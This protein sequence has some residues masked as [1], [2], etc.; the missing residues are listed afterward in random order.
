MS[1]GVPALYPLTEKGAR[2]PKCAR[3]RNHGMVSWL[4]GHKRHC[5]YKDCTC[6]K[7]N[8]IA[9]RQRVMAAQVALKRQQ[10]AEDAIAL[11]I[12]ACVSETG[13]PVMTQGPL[14]GPG[15]VTA[16]LD[17]VDPSMDNRNL[18]HSGPE[19][20]DEDSCDSQTELEVDSCSD[21]NPD[22]PAPGSR[23]QSPH[24][25]PTDPS[26]V[27]EDRDQEC[28]EAISATP[29]DYP[30]EA[31]DPSRPLD[32]SAAVIPSTAH[33]S[34][35]SDADKTSQTNTAHSKSGG[36]PHPHKT[37]NNPHHNH[38]SQYSNSHNNHHVKKEHTGSGKSSGSVTASRSASDHTRA[39]PTGYRPGRLTPLEILERVFP[40]QRRS[41]LELVLQGCNGDLVKAIEHFIS[42]QDTVAAQHQASL[43]SS[44]NAAAV[45][46]RQHHQQ[47]QQQQHKHQHHPQQLQHDG[48]VPPRPNPFISSLAAAAASG[49]AVFGHH[50]LNAITGSSNT[51][52]T[53]NNSMNVG[54]SGAGTDKLGFSHEL[55]G[56]GQAL[57]H[58]FHA[59]HHTP[60]AAHSGSGVGSKL[61][62]CSSNLK[63][64]FTPLSAGASTHGL[65]S[66]FT[67]HL[68]HFHHADAALR[69]PFF[70]QNG[71]GPTDLQ[72]PTAHHLA[73]AG[74]GMGLGV[75]P[76]SGPSYPGMFASPF[77]FHPYRFHFRS[78]VSPRVRTPDKNSDKSALTD[79]D[80]ISDSWDEAGSPRDNKAVD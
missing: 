67:S 50:H 49:H 70:A 40:L 30:A 29:S 48:P 52:T 65:H 20:C 47:Q 55:R 9:E 69:N 68:P 54:G 73:Y 46:Q 8:L 16:P 72:L 66:A 53:S 59:Q 51:G 7:C 32:G 10:A 31:S 33:S 34:T 44:S 3:C 6:P 17:A 27:N 24:H 26:V 11:G 75:S 1:G 77:S 18:H 37:H 38:H 22:S 61:G 80:H 2:K 15:T 79:S 28:Q 57:H 71:P 45:S 39:G 25:S 36:P 56:P 42:A 19:G 43:Q 21:K 12:R 60:P 63:S 64:A 76:L 23:I 35:R 5:K 62:S 4:K 14:W 58:P 78:S 13:I 41:V 74:L